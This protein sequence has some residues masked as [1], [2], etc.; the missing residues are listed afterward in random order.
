MSQHAPT[1]LDW[2]AR[3]HWNQGRTRPCRLCDGPTF[4]LDESA[5][6][7]HKTCAELALQTRNAERNPRESARLV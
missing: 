2:T 4:M 7:T 3:H 1:L 5:R 6:P